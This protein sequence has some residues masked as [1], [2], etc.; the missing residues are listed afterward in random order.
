MMKQEHQMGISAMSANKTN[1]DLTH[2]TI[3]VN[4]PSMVTSVTGVSWL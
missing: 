3:N 2:G 4:K 1:L